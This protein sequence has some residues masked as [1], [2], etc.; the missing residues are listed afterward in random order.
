MVSNSECDV[1]LQTDNLQGHWVLKHENSLVWHKTVF[2]WINKYSGKAD[3]M[4]ND[5]SESSMDNWWE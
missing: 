4:E 2:E 1:E 3:K 5:S